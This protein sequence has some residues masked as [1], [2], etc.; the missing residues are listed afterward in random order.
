MDSQNPE[1]R[2]KVMEQ[3]VFVV[4]SSE[5]TGPPDETRRKQTGGG[6]FSSWVVDQGTSC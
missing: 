2:E 4:S 5:K 3:C 1:C 6:G